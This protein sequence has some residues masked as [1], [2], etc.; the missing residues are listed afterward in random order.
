MT[1]TLRS[2]QL[3]FDRFL[4]ESCS[5]STCVLLRITYSTLLIVYVAILC[6]DGPLWFSTEGVIKTETARSLFTYPVFSIFYWVEAT[7]TQIQILLAIFLAQ[8]VA[9]LLGIFSRFQAACIFLWL[10]SFQHRN[11]MITDGEDTLFR[12]M[13]LFLA[14]MPLDA[15]FSVTNW[16]RNQLRKKKLPSASSSVSSLN[17][18]SR[19]E[20]AWAVRLLQTEMILLYASAALSKATSASWQDG[21]ALFY[22]YQMGDVYGRGWLPE[23]ITTETFWIQISTW[24]VTVVEAAIP[25]G[26]C[27]KPTRWYAILLGIALHLSIEY[28]MHLFL[29]Q[30]IM[31]VGLLAFVQPPGRKT[32]GETPLQQT[33]HAENAQTT[34]ALSP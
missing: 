3:K 26:L 34:T 24:S 12:I 17:W 16:L 15:G 7:P 31:I 23:F 18:R 2:I 33:P 19:S 27:W 21:S 11:P 8:A 14:L 10:L 5:P 32:L 9:M 6:I 4:F 22:V 1:P 25:L 13:A 28:A 30:W 29:F 20:S